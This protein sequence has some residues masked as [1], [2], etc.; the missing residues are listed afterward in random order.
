[1]HLPPLDT[2]I[3][4]IRLDKP[5]GILLLMWPCWWG[6]LAYSD[7]PPPSMLALFALGAL[8]MRSAGCIVNDMADR[9]IDAEV[10]R[11]RTRPLVSGEVTMRQAAVLLAIL[12]ALAFWVALCLGWK[13]A[14][15]GA[16]FLPLVAVYPYL[17]RFTWWPQAFLGITF[18]SGPVF[19][20]VAVTGGIHETGLLLYIA[21]IAWVIG[22]DTVYACQDRADDARIGVKST[23][24]LFGDHVRLGVAVFYGIALGCL[25]TALHYLSPPHH[26]SL[27]FACAC[28]ILMLQV[29]SLHPGDPAHCARLFRSNNWVGL[30]V[31]LAFFLR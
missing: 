9:S 20:M 1:M 19:G 4:L 28:F 2:M 22:Y 12:L 17:K 24:L 3:R 8:A 6:M 10:A 21:A 29:I 16:L 15:L 11:T 5:V 25:A 30:L 27:P 13:V 26:F 7:F 23:A 14:A 31:A 18:G